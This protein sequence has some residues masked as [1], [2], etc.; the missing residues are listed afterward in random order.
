MHG[1]GF[2]GE[3]VEPVV[4]PE[5]SDRR[6]NDKDWKENTVFDFLKQF[7]L[8]SARWAVDLVKNAEGIDD[9]TRHKA[10]FYIEQIANAS[11]RRILP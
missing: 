11:R 7:Y 2:L 3:S 1:S 9:H 8:I 4:A 10:R 6:F 5:R